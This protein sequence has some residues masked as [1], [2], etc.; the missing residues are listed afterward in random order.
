MVQCVRFI[1][2]KRETERETEQLL[3]ASLY[4]KPNFIT[5]PTA[6][7]VVPKLLNL[8]NQ[9]QFFSIQPKHQNQ[10]KFAFLIECETDVTHLAT[11]QIV[12]YS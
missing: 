3:C 11:L 8:P 4:I 1:L 10:F 9:M 12:I 2:V 5:T 6:N 7:Y